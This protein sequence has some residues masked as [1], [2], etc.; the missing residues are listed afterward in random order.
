MESQKDV[1]MI[2]TKTDRLIVDV[3]NLVEKVDK[4]SATLTWAKG[5]GI[6]AC[7]LI[8]ACAAFVWW[9]AGAKIDQMRD[10]FLGVRPPISHPA[11]PPPVRR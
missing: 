1:T 9:L 10:E 4:V 3:R 2:A 6:A 7:I 8:P 11:P 5:F